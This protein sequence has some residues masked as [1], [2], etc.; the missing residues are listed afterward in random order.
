MHLALHDHGVDDGAE[1]VHGR[2]LVHARAAR[3]RVNLH[4]ADVGACRKGEVGRVVERGFVEARLQHIQRIVV[5][6]IS[7]QRH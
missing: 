3:G 1:V 7:R 4:F 2:E 5:W 6:H